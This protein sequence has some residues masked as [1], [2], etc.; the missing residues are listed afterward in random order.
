MRAK[1]ANKN[2][3]NEAIKN[4]IELKSSKELNSNNNMSANISVS[5]NK[6]TGDLGEGKKIDLDCSS[7]PLPLLTMSVSSSTEQ[8]VSSSANKIEIK[9]TKS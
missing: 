4:K 8:L 6:K 2:N 9:K 5:Y 3:N 1:M 7:T